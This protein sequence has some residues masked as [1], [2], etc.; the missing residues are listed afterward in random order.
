MNN[1]KELVIQNIGI[2]LSDKQIEQFAKLADFLLETNKVMN[3]TAIRDIEG[4][5][6]KHFLDSLTLIKAI[7]ENTKNLA[8][9]GSGA[10]FPGIPLSIARPD[11]KITMIES[12]GKK[13]SFIQKSIDLL[14]LQNA[15]IVNDR[16]EKL[17]VHN[18][19]GEGFDVVTARAVTAL[20]ELIQLCIPLVKKDGVMIAMK[21]ENKEEL[22]LAERVLIGE[23]LEIKKIISINVPELNPRQ[24]I[25]IGR[26]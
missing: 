3:L 10:G 24:L 13:A 17:A 5:Y 2:E 20:P 19:S 15:K 21:S 6:M 22:E 9:I 7:P 25:V 23:N 4:I 26:K 1:F 18:K 16:A 8:D 12:I 11:I 14:E